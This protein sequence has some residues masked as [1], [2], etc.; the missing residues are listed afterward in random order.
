MSKENWRK[1][2][3]E[4]VKE[5]QEGE[6]H[7]DDWPMDQEETDYVD[8]IDPGEEELKRKTADMLTN[9]CD[10]KE[11]NAN[12]HACGKL[13]ATRTH[14]NCG[15]CGWIFCDCGSCKCNYTGK[16]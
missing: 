16:K 6:P 13:I 4:A 11:R 10:Y 2:Y 12:C 7:S 9:K 8:I 14:P 1:E 5:L 15:K 3:W